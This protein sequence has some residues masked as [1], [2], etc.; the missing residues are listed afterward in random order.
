MEEIFK[1]IEGFED[2]Q[3]SNLGRVKSFKKGREKILKNHTYKDHYPSVSL[4][5]NN[6]L[7]SKKVHQ[8]VAIAFL[9]H[10]PCGFKLVINHK[11]NI[12]TDNRVENLEIVTQRENSN[13]K[14][15]KSTS[16]YTGVCRNK[17]NKKWISSI[18]V[19]GKSLRLGYF[20][21]EK[22]AS[23]YYE[24]ALLSIQ[25]N[26]KIKIKKH[27]FTS[28]YK[29]VCWDR[30]SRKWTSSVKINGK[31]KHL[32]KFKTEQEASEYYQ[33]ALKSIEE[34]T[35][36]KVK[37]HIFSSN[38]K[39]VHW[40]KRKNKWISSIY[41]NKKRK[42]IGSFYSEIDARDAYLKYLETF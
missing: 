16:Q 6:K 34:G 33:N 30:I 18:Y 8:L 4:Y 29:G 39:G 13:Q 27:I 35:E 25:N 12:R 36:I 2:Y 3:I 10:K 24:N 5:K 1:Q 21:T 23:I 31:T 7:I 20:E 9:N 11:N 19:N 41:I 28:E 17:T 42:H 15:L 14:H 40:C 32:G 26:K 22:E 38:F 37:K